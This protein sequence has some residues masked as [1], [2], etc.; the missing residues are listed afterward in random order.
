MSLLGV[1]NEI[2]SLDSAG[3]GGLLLRSC[4]CM[5]AVLPNKRHDDESQGLEISRKNN[6]LSY[7]LI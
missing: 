3:G 7:L 1:G 5:K 6:I 2:Q 4:V